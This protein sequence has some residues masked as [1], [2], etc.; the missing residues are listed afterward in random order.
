MVCLETELRAFTSNSVEFGIFDS[1]KVKILYANAYEMKY[2]DGQLFVFLKISNTKTI[3][4]IL[5]R[6]KHKNEWCFC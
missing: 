2:E 6:L 5:T 3:V 4:S 1:I